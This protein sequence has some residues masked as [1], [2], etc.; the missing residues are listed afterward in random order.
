[1]KAEAIPDF[2][3]FITLTDNPGWVLMAQQHIEELSK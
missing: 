3:K 1:V 2:E